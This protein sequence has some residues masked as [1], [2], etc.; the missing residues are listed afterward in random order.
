M[1]E[2]RKISSE[3]EKQHCIRFKIDSIDSQTTNDSKT[4]AQIVVRLHESRYLH[5]DVFVP[6]PSPVCKCQSLNSSEWDSSIAFV[7]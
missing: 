1:A 6:F 4:E 5:P 7:D 3:S 2:E